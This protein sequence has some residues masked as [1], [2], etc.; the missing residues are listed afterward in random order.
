MSA[1]SLLS[2]L[3][4][5][6]MLVPLAYLVA[7]ALASVPSPRARKVAERPSHRFAIA[8]PAH[9][10]ESVI[11]DTVRRLRQLDYPSDLFDVHVVADHCSDQTAELVRAAGGVAHERTDGPRTG[12]GGAL[13]W[14][15]GRILADQAFDAVVVFDS[16]TRVDREFLRV[17]DGRLATGDQ[18]IQGQ[19]V[20]SNPSHG[21]FPALTWAM[22]LIDN[23]FSNLGRVNLGLSAKNMGDSICFRADILRRIGW[24]QG[25]TEDYQLRQR[26]L[27]EGTRIA[28]EPRAIG[29]GEAA[30]TWTQA[31]AQRARWLRG[32]RDASREYA[33]HLFAEGIRRLNPALLDGAIQAYFPSYSTL[34][35]IAMVLLVAQLAARSLGAAFPPSVLVSWTGLVGILF[36]YPLFGLALEKAPVRAYLVILSGPIFILWRSWLAF[37]SRRA[38]RQVVWVRTAHGDASAR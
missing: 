4:L 6:A 13:G 21:W 18:V 35:L 3:A 25:L 12:K 36:A 26:L 9:D 23:R 11:G 20:I 24:G 22:F 31:R 5:A 15:F 1:I 2:W 14:L 32:T 7:L 19:H 38:K 33:K 28:Y 27:L 16:D 37:Q 8:I 17:M 34:S 30:L 29:R 10:E